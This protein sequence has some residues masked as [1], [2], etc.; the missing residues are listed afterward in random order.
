M[1]KFQGVWLSRGDTKI[2]F[3]G[4]SNGDEYSLKYDHQNTR[5]LI[6]EIVTIYISTASHARLG[7]SKRFSSRD[8]YIIDENQIEIGDEFFRRQTISKLSTKQL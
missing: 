4:P 3:Y 1:I 8:I 6:E 7:D 5:D 2:E